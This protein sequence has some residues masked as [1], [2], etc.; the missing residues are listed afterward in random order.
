MALAEPFQLTTDDELKFVPFTVRVNPLPPA[1]FDVGLMDGVVGTG[2]FIVKVWEF[3][4]P[5]PGVELTTVTAA[6]PAIVM[7]DER[8][9]AVSW[10][11]ET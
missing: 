9:A 4:V 10:V 7:S 6:V 1:V 8:I 3:E 5:P 2:F 11:A